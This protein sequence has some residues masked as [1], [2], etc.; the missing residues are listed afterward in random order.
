MAMRGGEPQR[1]HTCW[2]VSASFG[3]KRSGWFGW[4]EG[5]STDPSDPDR[6]HRANPNR[7]VGSTNSLHA[8]S[9]KCTPAHTT[10]GIAANKEGGRVALFVFFGGG[11]DAGHAIVNRRNRRRVYTGART[12]ATPRHAVQHERIIRTL[13][14]TS[15]AARACTHANSFAA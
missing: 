7:N 8:S 4:G 2:A 11:S 14:Y 3:G 9:T 5:E 1:A 15:K 12:H 6:N 10:P 13:V